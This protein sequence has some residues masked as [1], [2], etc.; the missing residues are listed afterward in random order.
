MNQHL[1]S[2]IRRLLPKQHHPHQIMSGPLRGLRIVTSWS[3]YPSA[4][5]GY[6]ERALLKWLEATVHAGETWLDIGAHYGYTALAMS[7]LVGKDGRV[8]TFEPTLSTAGCISRT[9]SLN[10]IS[11]MTVT[12][13]GLGA[14]ATLELKRIATTRGMSDSTLTGGG[15]EVT[16]FVASFDWLWPRLCGVNARIDGV[17]IDVQ[18]MEIEVLRGMTS[19]LRMWKPRLAVEVH[20]GVERETLLALLESCGYGRDAKP[21][22]PLPGET[23]PQFLDNRSYAF[24]AR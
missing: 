22:D 7:R 15:D 11:N 18:G 24:T 19:W 21:I 3:D 6:N 1:K 20:A 14:P 10:N 23:A 5:I 13:M 2:T 12:P 16:I 8:F 17:K 9:V 4:I